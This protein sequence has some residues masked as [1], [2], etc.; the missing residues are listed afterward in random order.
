MGG[1]FEEAR[2][3]RERSAEIAREIEEPNR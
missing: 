1:A 3:L 2:Q